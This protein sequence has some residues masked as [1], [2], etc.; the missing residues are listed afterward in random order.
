M[1]KFGLNTTGFIIGSVLI[2]QLLAF[3]VTTL[4]FDLA[5]DYRLQIDQ[6]LQQSSEIELVTMGN[7][8]NLALDLHEFDQKGYHLWRNAGDFFETKYLLEHFLPELSNVRTVLI[9]AS[10]FTFHIKKSTWE[11]LKEERQRMYTVIPSWDFIDG[12]FQEFLLGKIYLIFPF[13]TLVRNDH[14]EMV[15]Q[16]IFDK[17]LRTANTNRAENGQEIVAKYMAC[18]YQE[19]DDLV[20]YTKEIGIPQHL[21]GERDSLEAHPNLP[22]EA[23]EVAIDLIQ[24]L[25]ERDIRIVFYTPPYF[26]AYTDLYDP[27]TVAVM[28]GYMAQLQQEYQ[29]EYYDFST[30]PDFIHDHR[31]FYDDDHLNLCGA[32]LFSAKFNQTLSQNAP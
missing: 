7:S 27:E 26:E 19:F 21:E 15:I 5:T 17:S 9:P 18:E 10:Y 14:W 28:K 2:A 12:E 11:I 13:E 23:Y 22:T 8:H 16:S 20:T 24:A 32:K 30:D 4:Q 25:Q 31:L 29:I 1:K 6:F 3:V